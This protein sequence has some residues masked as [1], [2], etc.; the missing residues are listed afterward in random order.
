[1]EII[2]K[3]I[4]SNT[5]KRHYSYQVLKPNELERDV[6]ILYV[7]DGKDYLE[8]GG[9][10]S[11]YQHL[12]EKYPEIEQKLIFVLIHPGTPM[13]RWHTY[14]RKG[15]FFSDY[16]DF[17]NDLFVPSIEKN[18]TNYSVRV[19]KRGLLGDSLAGNISLNIA[20]TSPE[21]WTHLLLQSA[22]VTERDIAQL[23]NKQ[24]LNWYVY[25]T[26]GTLEDDF[27]SPITNEPLHILTF[28]RLLNSQLMDS[29][30][31]VQY[32]EQNEDHLWTVWNN[33]LPEALEYFI[34]QPENKG[35]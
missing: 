13:E 17:M 5:L 25:Q 23:E 2:N 1:M 30:A 33:N 24:T 15:D 11:A 4:Y 31:Q 12:L 27:I 29:Q 9:L 6:S 34:T 28:N 26:V 8:L 32:V 18:L 14:H 16:V 3:K 19:V 10:M 35:T 21:R 20:I 22:A 7:Q